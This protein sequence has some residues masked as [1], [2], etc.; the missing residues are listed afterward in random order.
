VAV[1]QPAMTIEKLFVGD[2]FPKVFVGGK[3]AYQIR[4]RNVGRIPARDVIVRDTLPPELRLLGV[5]EGSNGEASPAGNTVQFP[6]GVMQPN[7]ERVVGFNAVAIAPGRPCNAASVVFGPY[8]VQSNEACLEVFGVD[9]F[10]VEVLP[11]KNPVLVGESPSF[12]I[13]VMNP[14]QTPMQ[15]QQL[16]VELPRN[17]PPEAGVGPTGE[18]F[19]A[20]V[21]RGDKTIIGHPTQVVIPPGRSVVYEVRARAAAPGLS[22]IK[23]RILAPRITGE[24]PYEQ[25]QSITVYNPDDAVRIERFN[26]QMPMRKSNGTP[27]LG[28][29]NPAPM[30][31]GTTSEKLDAASAT[32]TNPAKPAKPTPS[33]TLKLDAPEA[34]PATSPMDQTKTAPPLKE[35]PKAKNVAPSPP[36]LEFPDLPKK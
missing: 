26:T 20:P 35:L 17:L 5:T 16:E 12:I 18:P 27:S 4:V 11:N 2:P 34:K 29:I 31:A 7:E 30:T 1:Q 32:Q 9:A 3:V 22:K 25:D 14:G 10:N 24:L 33:F 36:P 23:V 6:I 21:N 8:V 28:P 19:V 13:K 15:I